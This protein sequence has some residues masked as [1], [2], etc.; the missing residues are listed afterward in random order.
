MLIEDNKV[1]SFHYCLSEDGKEVL[2]DSHG[3]DAMVYLHGHKGMLP[4]VEEAMT[5]KKAGD[6]F[7]ITLEPEKAYGA[8]QEN[9]VQRVSIK[10]V[11]NPGKKK[12]KY[13]A[14][15][16]IQLNTQEGP[17]DVM[18]VKAGL[19]TLD[20]D[21]NHPFA[22]KILKFDLEVVDVRDASEEEIS[23]GHVHGVGGVNH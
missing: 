3:G 10:H 8:V 22:G 9:A 18:I 1:V 19:K 17:R 6:S 5:G 12:V 13:K 20:V 14:G 7:T 23:H 15:M 11:I 16:K 4:G 2:E 21:T